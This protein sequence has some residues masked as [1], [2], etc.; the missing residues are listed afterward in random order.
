MGTKAQ[1]WQKMK[2]KQRI[3]VQTNHPFGEFTPGDVGRVQQL[4]CMKQLL[5]EV[6]QLS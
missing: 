5:L 1:T 3:Q 2:D 4:P 6:W